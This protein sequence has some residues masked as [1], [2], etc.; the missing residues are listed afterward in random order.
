[1]AV[2][3]AAADQLTR[4]LEASA[5][6]D[7]GRPAL[8]DR[9]RR[10][11]YAE[12]EER[13]NR[14]AHLLVELGVARGVR[15]GL[16]MEKSPDAVVGLYGVLKAGAAYVPLDP[17]APAE[18]IAQMARDC[19]LRVL[20]TGTEQ[21]VHWPAVVEAASL[22]TLVVLNSDAGPAVAESEVPGCELLY[23]DAVDAQ[24]AERP[25]GRAPR[26]H[27]M[28]YILYTSGST[29][30][31]K[32]VSLSHANALAFVEWSA[33]EFGLTSEDRVS[34]HAPLHF[35]LSIFDLFA[36][37]RAGATTVLIPR[38]TTVFPSQL[39]D[40]IETEKVTI[41]YSVPSALTMMLLRG[42]LRPGRLS[43]LR[44]VLF[45]GEVFPPKH[46]RR[47]MTL[48]PTA[49]FANLYGPTETNVCA[50]YPVPGPPAEDAEPVAIGRAIDGTDLFA[51]TEQGNVASVGEIGELY[52][53]GPTVMQG[54]WGDAPQTKRAL[55]RHPGAPRPQ[56]PAYRTGD[57]VWRD[58]VGDYHLVGRRDTQVKTRGYRVE[59][60]EIELVLHSHPAVVESTVVALADEVVTN[61]L[62][63]AVIASGDVRP[64][65][66]ASF[67]AQRLPSYMVPERFE[68]RQTLPKTSTGKADRQLLAQ[69]MQVDQASERPPRRR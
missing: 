43:S 7:A 64:E 1:V 50:W 62:A 31:P 16:Y 18:R 38:Q 15:V 34:N 67:C 32:G 58:Q 44:T 41:W 29:G 8:I 4:L 33:R 20:L 47:L 17:L 37:A 10:L 11:T 61:R 45:A 19:E 56:V 40:L 25:P 21:R 36:A 54:Y 49:R 55:V 52:V 60:S 27:D 46:L 6:A 22:E 35:D 9:A 53:Q 65:A 48:W 13:S 51:I 2:R 3:E 59:L 39:V 28:A 66:L 57:F 26:G 5:D 24:S 68:L 42:G 14:V 69:E 30:G 23:S 12:L 63:A